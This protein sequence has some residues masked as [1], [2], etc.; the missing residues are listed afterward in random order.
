MLTFLNVLFGTLSNN[1]SVYINHLLLQSRFAL[2][3]DRADLARITAIVGFN[4]AGLIGL[5]FIVYTL[6]DLQGTGVHTHTHRT[7]NILRNWT[8]VLNLVTKDLKQDIDNINSTTISTLQNMNQ[9]VTHNVNV[10]LNITREELDE[11]VHPTNPAEEIPVALMASK[12][13]IAST[14]TT[15]T[16]AS[17]T[18]TT[19]LA[20]LLEY[21]SGD[22]SESGIVI[23]GSGDFAGIKLKS[24]FEL[25]N[26]RCFDE[27]SNCD[28]FLGAGI[29]AR[30]GAKQYVPFQKGCR[31]TCGLCDQNAQCAELKEH[32]SDPGV[33]HVCPSTCME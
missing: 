30:W 22:G 29:C 25:F 14:T 16:A 18:S 9:N 32:C 5:Y 3:D 15:T 8:V 26:T 28:E 20:E 6:F 2:A 11:M 27:L 13:T 21:Y 24:S 31:K 33:R 4:F 19:K 10:K 23:D 12:D 17:T 1:I 7:H